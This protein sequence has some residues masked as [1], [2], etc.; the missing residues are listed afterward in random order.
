MILKL[1]DEDPAISGNISIYTLSRAS[2]SVTSR[3]CVAM[4]II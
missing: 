1:Y 3:S 2:Q 4:F